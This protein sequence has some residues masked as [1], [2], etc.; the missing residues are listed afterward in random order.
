VIDFIQKQSD[1]SE[2]LV[3]LMLDDQKERIEVFST[4]AEMN[5]QLIQKLEERD[6]LI[7]ELRAKL[8]AY[9]TAEAL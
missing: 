1:L 6:K 9:E 2:K 5:A 3:K 4:W 8:Q 7:A